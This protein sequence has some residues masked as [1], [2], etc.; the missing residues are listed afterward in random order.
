LSQFFSFSKK[1][2]TDETNTKR[3]EMAIRKVQEK[4]EG[5]ESAW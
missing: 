1:R 5:F 4:Q 3:K 2:I